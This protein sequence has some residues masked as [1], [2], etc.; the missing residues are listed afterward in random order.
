MKEAEME[1]IGRWIAEALEHRND[2]S[3][4]ERVRRQV[5]E[6]AEQFPLYAERRSRAGVVMA[7]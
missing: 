7:R 1:L 6:L 5:F 4:L 3:A 2:E